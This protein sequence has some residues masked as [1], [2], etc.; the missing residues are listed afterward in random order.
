MSFHERLAKFV[1]ENKKD[2]S[3]SKTKDF[4]EEA[5]RSF[6]SI[7]EFVSLNISLACYPLFA[8]N[9]PCLYYKEDPSI[10][11][12]KGEFQ[13]LPL[14][15]RRALDK[16]LWSLYANKEAPCG[17][18][19]LL[20]WV[21]PGG[22]GDYYAAVE[23]ARILKKAES[24]WDIHLVVISH[25]EAHLPKDLSELVS[26]HSIVYDAQ[27]SYFAPEASWTKE[28]LE[29]FS[30]SD[31]I[32]QIPMYYPPLS[33]AYE[34]LSKNSSLPRVD[35]VRQYGFIAS[36]WLSPPPLAK[37]MGLHGLEMGIFT[38]EVSFDEKIFSSLMQR[39]RL[40]HHFKESRPFFAYLVTGEGCEAFLHAVLTYTEDDPRA[41]DLYVHE[42]GWYLIHFDKIRRAIGCYG[43]SEVIFH[44]SEK[45]KTIP[46]SGRGKSLRL[47]HT[48]PLGHAEFKSLLLFCDTFAACRGD[49]S[50]S[51]MVCAEKV[52]FY[53]G[54]L[55][56]ADFLKDL[57]ALC[58]HYLPN[59]PSTVEY[60]RLFLSNMAHLWQQDPRE[61]VDEEFFAFSYPGSPEIVGK[62]MG[63]LLKDHSTKEGVFKLN[64]LLK[65]R[66]DVS[67]HLIAMVKRALIHKKFPRI[68]EKEEKL[69]QSLLSGETTFS[70]M[71]LGLLRL[72]SRLKESKDARI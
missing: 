20:S 3:L 52:Y 66:H 45:T 47:V 60:L 38:K 18:I 44:T 28:L 2:L 69:V 6:V 13:N 31:L 11:C 36:D 71:V 59:Y 33:A 68:A 12:L 39:L 62:K 9:L 25:K 37:S 26:F 7:E 40:S 17:K 32:L 8:R 51:E 46:L 55:H 42:M 56:A 58:R 43:I 54:L 24:S 1:Q 70:S 22:I 49:Q 23:T 30:K 21:V 63:A 64:C 65:Q 67:P 48:G 61:W 41:I 5:I 29:I 57:V 53:D 34:L 35:L 50:F 10:I 16:A 19:V 27:K 72:L 15:K 4:I 14:L